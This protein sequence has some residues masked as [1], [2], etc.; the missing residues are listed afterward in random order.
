[1]IEVRFDVDTSLTSPSFYR[2][3]NVSK[4]GLIVDFKAL[5]FRN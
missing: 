1:M 4:Y 2:G 3:S 5:Q